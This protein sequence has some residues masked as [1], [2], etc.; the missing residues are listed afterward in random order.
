MPKERTK[1]R[2]ISIIQSKG[3]LFSFKKPSPAKKEYN[4]K[5]ISELRQ[6]LSNEKARMLYIIKNQNP[7]SIYD[8][9]KKLDRNFKSVSDDLSVLK[10]FGLVEI[11]EEHTKKRKKHKPA[12]VVDTLNI[13]IK[14]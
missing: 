9:A 7:S 12:L 1:T 13:T 10:K 6:I 8:L 3:G 4:F 2:E 5:D 14:L 11:K